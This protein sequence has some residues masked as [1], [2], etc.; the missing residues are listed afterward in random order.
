MNVSKK[1]VSSSFGKAAKS[2]NEAAVVQNEILQRLLSRLTLLQ[3]TCENILDLGSGTGLAR[4]SIQGMY[5]SD[6][7]I[8]LDLAYPM[9]KYAVDEDTNNKA[10][11]CVCADFEMLPIK[12][13]TIE[14]IFSASSLQWCNDFQAAFQES[15]RALKIEGLFIFS[16]FGP[17]TLKEIKHCFSQIDNDPHVKVFT[18]MH[19]LG[20]ILL[21]IGFT[22]P[23]MESEIITV[24]Y[25]DPRQL[26]RDLKA[27]G[28]T[29]HLQDRSRGLMGKDRLN[30][31]L[32]EYKKFQLSNGKYPASYEVI[33]GHGRKNP[34]KATMDDSQE[35]K[36]IHFKSK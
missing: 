17:D 9:L 20:D 4:S 8:A 33:Y 14:T 34:P 13:N 36:P 22:S 2:Y 32:E 28:A 15:F 21:S 31:V 35:W 7:Y 18:D 12:N 11:N 29:N 25:S 3:P 1:D 27:T 5:G 10:H 26:F 16:T 19:D 6:A 23:V 30:A 24:E